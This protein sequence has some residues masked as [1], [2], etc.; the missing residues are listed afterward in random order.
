MDNYMKNPTL[1]EKLVEEDEFSYLNDFCQEISTE[2][3]KR[4]QFLFMDNGKPLNYEL[5]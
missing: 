3:F 1:V 2:D 5:L 4:Q